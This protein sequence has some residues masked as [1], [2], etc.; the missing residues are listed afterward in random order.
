MNHPAA[1]QI[2]L[3]AGGDMN[4]LERWRMRRHVAQC[5]FCRREIEA[6]RSAAGQVRGANVDL[7]ASVNWDRL[8]AEMSA[9]IHLG[10][11]AGECVATPVRRPERISWKAAAVVAGMTVMLATGWWLNAPHQRQPH[12][13]RAAQIEMRTTASGIQLNENGNALTLLHTRGR[14]KPII[15]SAPGTLRARFVDTETGQV[16]INNVYTE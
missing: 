9:N 3:Y 1:S 15:V 8:A 16:T 6:F 10:L 11:E 7:P 5:D 4:V 14:Q 12:A 13:I 2:A